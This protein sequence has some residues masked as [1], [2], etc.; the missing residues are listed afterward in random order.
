MRGYKP[1]WNSVKTIDADAFSGCGEFSITGYAGSVAES[2]ANDN[3]ITFI[4]L[5]GEPE[6]EYETGDVNGDGKVNT[7]DVTTLRRYLAGG[8]EDSITF[9]TEMIDVNGDGREN[10]RD[11]ATLRSIIAG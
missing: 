4:A 6:P 11:V 2:F 3:G 9:I 7:R 1:Q 8:Y 10:T 5:E